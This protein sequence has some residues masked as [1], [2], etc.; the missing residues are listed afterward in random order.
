M[1]AESRD[2]DLHTVQ[3]ASVALERLVTATRPT[4]EG[5]ED[6]PTVSPPRVALRSVSPDRTEFECVARTRVVLPLGTSLWTIDISV[7]GTFVSGVPISP[8]HVRFFAKTSAV[9]VLWPFA[10]VYVDTIATLAG[11]PA[12]PLPLIVRSQ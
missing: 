9:Y 12:P 6:A 2:P 10:R 4:R 8:R 3:L 1:A 11:M 5:D 7:R